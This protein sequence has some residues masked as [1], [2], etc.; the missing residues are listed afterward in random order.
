MTP[1]PVPQ[2]PALWL[3][4]TACVL[5][6]IS[7]A[8]MYINRMPAAATAFL[9]MLCL[10]WSGAVTWTGYT[11]AFWGIAVAAA[12]VNRYWLL[13]GALASSHSG[14]P[15]TATGAIAGAAVGMTMM[16]ASTIILGAAAGALFGGI[17]YA[18]TPAGAILAFPS[19]R[20]WGWMGAKAL[21]AIVTASMAG[22]TGA[23]LTAVPL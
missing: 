19:S 23:A 17:I 11:L 18:R 12:L 8:G 7:L 1:I 4:I 6:G 20:F 15:Y 2:E 10:E 3:I 21:P 9:A 13:P 22:L 5:T 14:T 16:H